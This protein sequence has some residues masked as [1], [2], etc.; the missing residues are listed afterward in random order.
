M[1][2]PDST[3][4]TRPRIQFVIILCLV[5]VLLTG[6]ASQ[7]VK[8]TGSTPLTSIKTPSG[9]YETLEGVTARDL[10]PRELFEGEGYQILD[11]VTPKGLAYQ[12]IL[13]SPY[14]RFEPQGMDMLQIR[15]REILALKEVQDIGKPT[16]FGLGMAY[17]ALSPFRF[18]WNMVTEPSE[19]AM[20][21]P[22]GLWKT[23]TRIAEMMVGERGE[24]EE[25]EGKELVGFSMAKRSVAS[26]L[27][28]DAYSSNDTLQS[29][30][31]KVALAGYAGGMSTKLA[32]MPITGPAGFALG[33]ALLGAAMNDVFRQNSPED[34]RRMNRE[35]LKHMKVDEDLIGEFL[36]HRWYSPRHETLLVQ[37]LADMEGT[38][39]REGFVRVALRAKSEEGALFFQRLAEMMVNYH[40]AV[41]PLHKL[42]IIGEE[43]ILGYTD[44][45]ALVRDDPGVST[46]VDSGCRASG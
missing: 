2:C 36:S 28:I 31:E 41:V 35:L 29:A 22:K 11:E 12:F 1:S 46:A 10:L 19:T 33:G 21:V 6:C 42:V 8:S 43:L 13:D 17:I 44:D 15:I 16:A 39:N 9:E 38:H 37:A 25:S 45:R 7:T 14:G 32:M 4:W 23:M 26:Y 20:G 24:F 40:Q 30:I 18:I 5:F 3:E 27:G 34:L